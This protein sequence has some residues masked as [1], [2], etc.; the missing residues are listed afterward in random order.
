MLKQQFQLKLS[1]KLSPQQIQLMKMIQLTTLDFEQRLQNEIEEN[2]ALETGKDKT[3]E[4]LDDFQ[5]D[6]EDHETIDTGE[7]DIDA[8]LSDDKKTL[9][10]EVPMDSLIKHPDLLDFEVKLK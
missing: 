10:I 8:Y 9:T 1:Q 2:P 4:P 5:D 7:I 6:F 3:D